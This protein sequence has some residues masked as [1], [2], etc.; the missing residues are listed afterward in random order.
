MHIIASTMSSN[1]GRSYNRAIDRMVQAMDRAVVHTA[2]KPTEQE[3]PVVR[4]RAT[5]R[6]PI[7]DWRKAQ[8][9]K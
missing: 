1:A 9:S 4:Y 2:Y 7:F 8:V 6:K 5:V 3:C